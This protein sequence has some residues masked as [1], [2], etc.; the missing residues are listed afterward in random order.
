MKNNN[1]KNYEKFKAFPSFILATKCSVPFKNLYV[2]IIPI[3]TINFKL[4][5]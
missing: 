1:K 4:T 5:I 2:Y 3:N